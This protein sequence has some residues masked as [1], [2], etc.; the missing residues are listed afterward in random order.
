MLRSENLEL[1][2]KGTVVVDKDRK[3]REC[4]PAHFKDIGLSSGSDGEPL[5]S[6][7]QVNMISFVL[8]ITTVATLGRTDCRSTK[9]KREV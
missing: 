6:F 9:M 2:E 3:G 5:N 1:S 4:G 7:E 8:K